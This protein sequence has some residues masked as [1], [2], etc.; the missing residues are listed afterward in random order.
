MYEGGRGMFQP[1]T[2]YQQPLAGGGY[3]PPPNRLIQ[4]QGLKG[5]PVSS[6]EEARAAVVDFDG[7]IFLFPD[8]INKRIYTKQI[9][10]DGTATLNMYQLTALPPVPQA[11]FNFV[12]KDDFTSAIGEL[13]NMIAALQ[14]KNAEPASA[15]P[16]TP[17]R[18]VF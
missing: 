13:K 17:T 10:M 8:I 6:I 4:Q 3:Y 11:D 16:Q 12:T 7:S 15:N 14:Q 9:N 2:Q 1:I 5:Y 18:P